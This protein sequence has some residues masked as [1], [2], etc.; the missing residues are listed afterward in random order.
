MGGAYPCGA[1]S[2]LCFAPPDRGATDRCMSSWGLGV[3]CHGNPTQFLGGIPLGPWICATPLAN[4]GNHGNRT[5]AN[6]A[7]T[8]PL[9]VGPKAHGPPLAGGEDTLARGLGGG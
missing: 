3:G 7:N 1:S 4:R 9:G 8:L 2:R 6:S 5:L